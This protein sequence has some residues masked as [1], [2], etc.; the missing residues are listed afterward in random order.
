[1]SM[2]VTTKL[3]C[4]FPDCGRVKSN[5]VWWEDGPGD[6]GPWKRTR[7]DRD[8]CPAHTE[9]EIQDLYDKGLVVNPCRCMACDP[10]EGWL[11]RMYVCGRCG[12]KRCPGALDHHYVVNGCEEA[13][14]HMRE[15]V[16]K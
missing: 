2:V 16:K 15:A 7:D 9:A 8:W 1:M 12:S 13:Q 11:R 10:P 5:L 4:D 3:V 14:R 6:D